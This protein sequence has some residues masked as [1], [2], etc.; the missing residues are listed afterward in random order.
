MKRAVLCASVIVALQASI[1]HP[2]AAA[3]RVETLT[4]ERFGEFSFGSVAPGVDAL[5]AVKDG[6]VYDGRIFEF[7]RSDGRWE[8][9]VVLSANPAFKCVAFA[10]GAKGKRLFAGQEDF[11]LIEA[12]LTP[13]GW[14]SRAIRPGLPK[15]DYSASANSYPAACVKSVKLTDGRRLDVVLDPDIDVPGLACQEKDWALAEMT[16]LTEADYSKRRVGPKPP[17]GVAQ[18][19]AAPKSVYF[20]ALVAGDIEGAGSA[21]LYGRMA[22]KGEIIELRKG[23]GDL[24]EARALPGSLDRR[25][26][27]AIGPARNDGIV[28][29]Y[30]LDFLGLSEYQWTGDSWTKAAVEGEKFRD[31]LIIGSFRP[32]GLQR[33]YLQAGQGIIELTYVD[34]AWRAEIINPEKGSIFHL[35]SGHVSGLPGV[36]LF[37]TVYNIGGLFHLNWEEGER[38]VVAD[39]QHSGTQSDAARNFSDLLRLKLVQIGNCTVLERERM[40]AL[41]AEHKFQ[42]TG[43]TSPEYAVRLGR[44]LN[45]KKVVVGE[46][47]DLSNAHLAMVNAVSVETGVIEKAEYQQWHSA[48]EMDKTIEAV[49]FAVCPAR[50]VPE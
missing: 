40:E 30:A 13:E 50:K 20:R 25:S 33:L 34:A 49:A 19:L 44:L 39:F 45:A 26:Y 47:G 37:F 29:L 38:V 43:S 11:G 27:M 21:S 32:D 14:S 48:E 10:D 7:V 16:T 4:S 9:K 2:A 3:W 23:R 5:F 12:R 42:Q 22:P 35:A 17:F 31:G 28:R 18:K 8:G 36:Q 46:L 24:W 1:S 41:L 15:E 6:N